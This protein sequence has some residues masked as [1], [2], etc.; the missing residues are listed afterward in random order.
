MKASP[1]EFILLRPCAPFN[2]DRRGSRVNPLSVGIEFLRKCL[3]PGCPC[4]AAEVDLW[5]G[6][7]R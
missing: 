7:A 1:A 2:H 3:V 4:T 6:D 5:Y